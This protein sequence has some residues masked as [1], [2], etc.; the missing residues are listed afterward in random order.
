ML[1]QYATVPKNPEDSTPWS[2]SWLSGPLLSFV[3]IDGFKSG[4][5][6]S[7]SPSP[8][9]SRRRRCYQWTQQFYLNLGEGGVVS[10][11]THCQ[12]AQFEGKNQST[13]SCTQGAVAAAKQGV[14][15]HLACNF[16]SQFVSKSYSNPSLLFTRRFCLHSS[17]TDSCRTQRTWVKLWNIPRLFSKSSNQSCAEDTCGRDTLH[18]L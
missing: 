4:F 1:E 8:P 2:V 6:G 14:F 7:H 17:S 9:Y 5:Q 18:S 15:S 3:Q 11:R 16:Y 12:F 10:E 13:A